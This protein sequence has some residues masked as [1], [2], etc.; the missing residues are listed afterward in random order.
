MGTRIESGRFQEV[1]RVLGVCLAIAGNDAT[2][3]KHSRRLSE[4]TD[5]QGVWVV[6]LG[7]PRNCYKKNTI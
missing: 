2:Q 1:S 5:N 3:N 6:L 7:R 4:L